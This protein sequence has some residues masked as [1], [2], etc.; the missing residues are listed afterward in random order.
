MLLFSRNT[1][2]RNREVWMVPF[3]QGY[4][5]MYG[6]KS[7]HFCQNCNLKVSVSSSEPC[8]YHMNEGTERTLA[9][10]KVQYFAF[11]KVLPGIPDSTHAIRIITVTKGHPH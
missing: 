3:C 5:E 4:V 6:G 9:K 2:E 8:L 11:H 7:R 1:N 10:V